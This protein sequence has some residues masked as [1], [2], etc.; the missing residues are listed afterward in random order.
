[1]LRDLAHHLNHEADF[2][3]TLD[4][5]RRDAFGQAR[6]YESVLAELGDRPAG[7]ATYFPMYST[8]K[9]RPCLYLD[10]LFVEDWARGLRVGRALMAEVCRVAVARDC[11][12]VELK[13]LHNNPARGFYEALGMAPSA[14]RPYVIQAEAMHRL[15]G[16]T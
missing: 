4:D 5:V 14:E 7:L 10:N 1:M 16:E 9:G 8:Y 2:T 12:R 15:T 11:C 3:A 6:Q 13:V